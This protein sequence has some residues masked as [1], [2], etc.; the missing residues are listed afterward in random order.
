MIG[1]AANGYEAIKCGLEL[2]PDLVLLD[3]SMPDLSGLGAIKKIKEY[4]PGTKILV[5]TMHGTQDYLVPAFKEGAD[6][7]LLKGADPEELFMACKAVLAG[8]SYISSEISGQVIQ[9]FLTG[10]PESGSPLDAL[11]PRELEILKLVVEGQTNKKI[12]E[13]LCISPKTVDKHRSNLMKKLDLHNSRQLIAFA[14]EY[15]VLGV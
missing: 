13:L 1:E 8:H 11:T 14:R 7:Y 3:L 4:S 9:G 2:K 15:G 10:S 5:I 6:G 12:G